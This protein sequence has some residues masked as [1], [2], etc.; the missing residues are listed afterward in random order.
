MKTILIVEDETSVRDMIRTFLELQ[1]FSVITASNGKDGLVLAKRI[2]PDL[3]ISDIMMPVMDGFQLKKELL[4]DETAA[5]TP[6]IFLTSMSEREKVRKGMELGAD[7]YLTKPVIMEELKEAIS[8]QLEKRNKLLKEYMKKIGKAPKKEYANNEHVL[9]KD[10]GTPRFVKIDSIRCIT[11]EDKYTKV[12]LNTNE[13]IISSLSLKE[14]ESMI[15]AKNFLRIHR[16][17]IINLESIE[18]VD[19]WFQRSYKV[20]IKGIDEGFE[21]SRR[22]YSKIREFYGGE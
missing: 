3:I 17:T 8:V 13:K 6:F 12:F 4:K 16:A 15:P 18:K 9:L 20:K 5:T 10:K 19:K 14:W 22:Y 2:L 21:I 1:K 11:A 7:D